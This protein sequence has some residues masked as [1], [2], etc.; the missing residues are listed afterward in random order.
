[1]KESELR[2]TRGIA[3][4]RWSRGLRA[5]MLGSAPAH[6]KTDGELVAEDINGQLVTVLGIAT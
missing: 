6:E 3:A 2:I 5:A 4:V 1:M